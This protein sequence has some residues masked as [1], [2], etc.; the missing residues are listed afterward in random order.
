M[1]VEDASFLEL[2]A[3]NEAIQKFISIENA[4]TEKRLVDDTCHNDFALAQKLLEDP[5]NI[6]SISRRGDW[7]YTFRQDADHPRGRWL[8]LPQ[9]S[10]PGSEAPW[11]M[12]FD[13]DAFCEQTALEWKW[14]RPQTAW[15]NPNRVM[16]C[17]HL[18]GSDK[19]RCIEFDCE[20]KKIV[21]GGFDIPPETGSVDWL[22][23]NTLLWSTAAGPD[24][25]TRSGWPRLVKRLARG[26]KLSEASV[27]FS[28]SE[29]DLLAHAYV[30]VDEAKHPTICVS[31]YLEIGKEEISIIKEGVPDLVLPSPSDTETWNTATHFAYVIKETGGLVGALMLG[32][33]GSGSVREVFTPAKRRQ[34]K[35]RSIRL[36]LNWMLWI[37]VDNL[38]EHLFVLDISDP[39]AT[40]LEI[41]IPESGDNIW[42]SHHDANAATSDG[43]L[44]LYITGFLTSQRVYLFD[45]AKGP[46][47][48]NWRKLW[49]MPEVFDASEMQVQVLEAESDDGTMVPYHLVSKKTDDPDMPVLL[50]GYGGYGISMHPYYDRLTG[51]LWLARGG[52][53]VLTHIRGG[54]ELGPNW[55]LSAIRA[56]RHKAFEDF[57]S[58]AKDLTKRGLSTPAH[59]ACHGHS[60][61]GLLAGV[62]L[63][64]YPDL[65][66]AVWASVGTL[67]ML[68]FHMFPAGQGWIDEYGD[69]DDPVA[70]EWLKAYSPV[71]QVPSVSDRELPPCLIDTHTSDD[72]VD[73]SHSRRFAAVLRAA[74]HEPVFYEHTDGGHSGGA[75][76]KAKAWEQALGF[77]FL[78]QNIGK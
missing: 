55:H 5:E 17:L 7:I 29:T 32:E 47:E 43:T 76:S 73:P 71:H 65:F 75:S 50:Y 38:K 54:A 60:N 52:A 64:R 67:D 69:P 23:A 12:V 30:V 61:G 20:Q 11:E 18:N 34:I 66:G 70:R 44:Q 24:S 42:V 35:S 4:Q 51:A 62:M 8:R 26:A 56:Q 33:I 2:E 13:L 45:L 1:A 28:A 63:T 25:A 72:R 21:S 41:E 9:G 36:L 16:L 58:I 14:G 19:R 10:L 49:Q 77:S 74:G 39:T 3:D 6:S 59:I 40:K 15:F 68:R 37:E 22:D 53:Y 27:I 46:S 31:R 57:A 48:I 78:R